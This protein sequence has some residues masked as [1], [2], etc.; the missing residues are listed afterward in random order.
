MCE[1]FSQEKRSESVTGYCL[2]LNSS[3]LLHFIEAPTEIIK[4]ILR[5]ITSQTIEGT[6]LF[7]QCKICL[8]SEE[9]PRE[10]P[11]WVTR[12]VKVNPEEC[13]KL[14]NPAKVC[15]EV[16][17]PFLELARECAQM[18]DEKAFEFLEKSTTKNFL[19]KLPS[20][21]KLLQ[22]CDCEE[23]PTPKEWLDI[24]DSPVDMVLESEKVWPV[25]PWLKY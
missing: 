25:E 8:F 5:V 16:Y 21:E 14:T 4:E 18:G 20:A 17:K 23:I 15:F 22:F 24:F 6:C 3:V 19:N 12:S 7:T 9:V 11:F 13:E 2:I 1:Y 10:F